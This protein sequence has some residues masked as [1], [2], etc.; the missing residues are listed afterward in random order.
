MLLVSIIYIELKKI[1]IK[2]KQFKMDFLTSVLVLIFVTTVVLFVIHFLQKN[3]NSVPE[4]QN[5]KSPY[6]YIDLINDLNFKAE[7]SKRN[8]NVMLL[9]A[10]IVLI[11][12]VRY[13]YLAT[14][15]ADTKLDLENKKISEMVTEQYINKYFLNNFLDYIFLDSNKN[16]IAKSKKIID[17]MIFNELISPIDTLNYLQYNYNIY[18]T[19]PE[20]LFLGGY[21]ETSEQPVGDVDYDRYQSI[22]NKTKIYYND[23]IFKKINEDY[24]IVYN[25]FYKDN[26]NERFITA[27]SIRILM[28]LVTF[29]IAQL[30]IKLYR[31]QRQLSEYYYNRIDAINAYVCASLNIT[32]SESVKLF[33][34][35]ISFG[36]DLKLPT[37]S[38]LELVN[39]ISNIN[40][41]SSSSNTSRPSS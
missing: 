2:F 33:Q 27:M 4:N 34:H 14:E 26:A 35:N 13:I 3:D 23:S 15:I 20:K 19:E 37:D 28:S 39:T 7:I 5:P 6:S 9:F 1:L 18:N 38:I 25:A 21:Y 36:K 8:S 17:S 32:L 12:G 16:R 29:F 40:K 10:F 30:F 11:V 31:Y 41:T 24:L 22:I